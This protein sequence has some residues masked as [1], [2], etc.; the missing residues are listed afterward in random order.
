[1]DFIDPLLI[2]DSLVEN[3]IGFKMVTRVKIFDL[4]PK[5]FASN[6]LFYF[7]YNTVNLFPSYNPSSIQLSDSVSQKDWVKIANRWKGIKSV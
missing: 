4:V 3:M 1:M 6:I 7:K 5:Y 2:I